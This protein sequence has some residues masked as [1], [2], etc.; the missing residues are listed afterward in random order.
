MPSQ[1]MP[2]AEVH[3]MARDELLHRW[4]QR[5]EDEGLT[6]PN[7]ESALKGTLTIRFDL[8][9]YHSYHTWT[10]YPTMKDVGT[11]RFLLS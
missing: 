11:T 5:I 7:P 9:S 3:G 2:S 6:V 10:R 8:I 4:R 1:E